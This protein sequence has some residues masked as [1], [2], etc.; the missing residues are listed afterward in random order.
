[1]SEVEKI[2]E[3]LL[4]LIGPN[5]ELLNHIRQ[6]E[7]RLDELEASYQQK[8]LARRTRLNSNLQVLET[9]RQEVNSFLGSYGGDLPA[10]SFLEKF[11]SVQIREKVIVTSND[12]ELK[13]WAKDFD[14]AL[15]VQNLPEAIKFLK[16]QNQHILLGV[17]L[18]KARKLAKD[19]VKVDSDTPA[20]VEEYVTQISEKKF[21]EILTSLEILAGSGDDSE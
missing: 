2:N 13:R 9:L 14:D 4:E 7:A 11:I 10:K 17:D 6:D 5:L 19:L 21:R 16:E 12:D 18:K 8:T 15:E 20:D 3:K 1:M